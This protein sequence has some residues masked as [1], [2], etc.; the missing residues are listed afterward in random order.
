MGFLTIKERYGIIVMENEK[1]IVLQYDMGEIALD[2]VHDIYYAVNE[3]AK[4]M[5]MQVIVIPSAIHW[6]EMSR[7]ELIQMRNIIDWILEKKHDSNSE[8][9][10]GS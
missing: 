3:I 9:G 1:Y 8:A 4:H 7:E 2:E 5:N 6:M 10:T